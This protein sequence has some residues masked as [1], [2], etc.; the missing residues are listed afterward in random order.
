MVGDEDGGWSAGRGAF[1]S[2]DR[3]DAMRRWLLAVAML[4]MCGTAA[5]GDWP[6]FRGPGGQGHAPPEARPRLKFSDAEG[7]RWRTPIAG[8]GWSSPVVVERE[9]WLTTAVDGGKSLRVVGLDAESGA[10]RHDV[11]VIRLEDPG[12]IHTKN[13]HASPTPVVAGELIVAHFGAH[14]TAAVGRDGKLRWVNQELK[15]DHRHGPGGSPVVWRDLVL[16]SA[17]GTD[18]QAVVALE[19]ATGKVRWKKDREGPMAYHT[20]LVIE[21]PEG[22]QLVSC[23]GNQVVSYDPATGEEIWRVRYEGYSVVPRPVVAHGLVFFST[24]YDS[25]Q[26]YAVRTDGR[27]D[28]TE[29]HVAWTLRRGAPHNPSPLVVG[30]ELYVV[31]D[32]GVASCLEARTGAVRWQQ[33]LGGKFSASPLLAAG[34]IYFLDEEGKC[35]V[36]AARPEFERLAENQ[37]KGRT[38]ASL[39]LDGD[40][41]LLRTDEAVL[42]FDPER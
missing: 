42:C 12:P 30:D 33:R 25:P 20:P 35:T 18:R 16:L 32:G 1:L 41:L 9:I 19:L 23:G 21:G 10:V 4:G 37:V 28:V 7:V 8:L 5:A 31:S 39:S 14:G 2:R 13:S 15:Y 24:G 40:R 17:D 26:L 34:R 38:L 29:T 3:G 11:E 6:Q 36:I 22:A 27:G